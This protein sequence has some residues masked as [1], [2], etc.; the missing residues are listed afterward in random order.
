MRG[1]GEFK[2]IKILHSYTHSLYTLHFHTT[3]TLTIHTLLSPTTLA[4]HTILTQNIHTIHTTLTI[5][6][7]DCFEFAHPPHLPGAV[8]C[9]LETTSP[10][11]FIFVHT[12][13]AVSLTV[14]QEPSDMIF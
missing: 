7:L 1:V 14:G 10:L 12:Y 13:E 3:T 2:I 9:I 4:T 5:H 11:G 8:S 6:K